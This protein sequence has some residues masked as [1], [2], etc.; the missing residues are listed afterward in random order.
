[1]NF[2]KIPASPRG[3]SGVLNDDADDAFELTLYDELV[4]FTES[5]ESDRDYS[6]D[7]F[8]VAEPEIESEVAPGPAA[9]PDPLSQLVH[10][11]VEDS[12]FEALEDLANS[13]ATHIPNPPIERFDDSAFQAVPV[14]Q[15]RNT[16]DLNRELAEM[17]K[18][19][20][21]LDPGRAQVKKSGPLNLCP[22]CKSVSGPDDLF[23]LACGALLG[24]ADLEL[25]DLALCAECGAA[26]TADEVFCA[27]CGAVLPES[28]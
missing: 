27:S 5:P 17:L 16:S 26:T 6:A 14:P 8:A 10:P 15:L 24:E 19:T 20:G 3:H 9:G 4:A 28:H 25:E 13:A 22:E 7:D 18:G 21:P 12:P 2:K 11:A 23:C 1:M